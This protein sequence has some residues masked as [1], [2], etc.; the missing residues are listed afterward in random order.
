MCDDT[1]KRTHIEINLEDLPADLGLRK[2]ILTYDPNVQD[3][4]C[5]AYL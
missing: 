4:I 3:Q 5:R 1:S 2:R